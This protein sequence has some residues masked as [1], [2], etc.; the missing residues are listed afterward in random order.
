MTKIIGLTGRSGAGKGAAC[1]IF[2]KHGIPCIDTDAV[3]HEILRGKNACTAELAAYFG[4]NILSP[5]GGVYRLALR[6]AVFGQE[7][8]AARLHTLNTITHKYIMTK[9]REIV[10]HHRDA[11]AP[12]VVIDAPQL[13][14]AGVEKEC[15]IVLGI[16]ADDTACISRI[17]QRDNIKKKAAVQRLAAQHDNAYF[18]ARCDAVI[19]NGGDL[20]ELERNI[21]QF[22]H[23]FKVID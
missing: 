4:S 1:A 17:L 18:L 6:E 5:E 19:E 2:E 9:T 10:Q 20:A 14:E 13:F 12:A 3:Y 15:N 11:G 16:L 8:S 22:L 21:C 23:E 7:D